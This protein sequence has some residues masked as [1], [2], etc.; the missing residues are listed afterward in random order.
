MNTIINTLLHN[1]DW[2]NIELKSDHIGEPESPQVIHS[3]ILRTEGFE[4][5]C[6]K[7]SDGQLT[8]D[9]EDVEGFLRGCLH[10][11]TP[12]P[13]IICHPPQTA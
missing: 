2:Q 11:L 8:F 10:C 4:L 3:G 1:I 12:G 9:L 13:C 6:Y 7:L 5:R